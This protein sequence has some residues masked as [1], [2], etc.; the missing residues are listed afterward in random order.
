MEFDEFMCGIDGRVTVELLEESRRLWS[1]CSSAAN[2]DGAAV[3]TTVA[4]AAA[5]ASALSKV[6]WGL[7]LMS[8]IG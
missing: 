5:A 6:L 4:T 3:F 7:L 8:Q 1:H 2:V